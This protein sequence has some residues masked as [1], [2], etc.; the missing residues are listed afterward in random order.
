VS[1][2]DQQLAAKETMVRRR[3]GR[4]FLESESWASSRV[5]VPVSRE[6]ETD[7]AILLIGIVEEDRAAP[8]RS[9]V[10]RKHLFFEGGAADGDL[11]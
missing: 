7:A 3:D 1:R 11:N 5:G 2:A 10:M 9:V 4:D 8:S 6:K